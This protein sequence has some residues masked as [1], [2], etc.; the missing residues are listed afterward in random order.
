MMQP[1]KSLQAKCCNLKKRYKRDSA[2][3]EGATSEMLQPQEALQARYW[4]DRRYKQDATISKGA[5]Y[6]QDCTAWRCV[7][8]EMLQPQKEIRARCC[9]LKRRYKRYSTTLRGASNG[10]L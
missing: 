10:M 9:N 5:S 4:S 3:S 7:I 2:I 6:K 1:K 8:N